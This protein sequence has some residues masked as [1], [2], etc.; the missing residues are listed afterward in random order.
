MLVPYGVLG[1]RRSWRGALVQ[2]A[3]PP[4]PAACAFVDPA[5]LHHI[6][7]LGPAGAGGAAGAIYEFLGIRRDAA[8]PPE[9]VAAVT[10]TGQAK[11]HCYPSGTCIHVIGPDFRREPC[12]YAGARERLCVAYVNVLR[13][14]AACDAPAL[15]LLPISGGIFAGPFVPDVPRLTH[16]ALREACAQLAEAEPH[17]AER[18]AT[19]RLEL[20]I[21]A[22]AEWKGFVAAGFAHD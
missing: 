8:F 13:E 2:T 15:R 12:D 14:Y 5:G 4:S 1:T 9:V 17:V 22:E 7:Q 16:D 20:C 11:A 6:Q 18:L 19:R 3:P 10:G 21:F